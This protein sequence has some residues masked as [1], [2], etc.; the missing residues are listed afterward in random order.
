MI[1]RNPGRQKTFLAFVVKGSL[2]AAKV[3]FVSIHIV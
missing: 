3:T 1:N 2:P